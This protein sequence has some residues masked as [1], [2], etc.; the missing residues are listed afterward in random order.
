MTHPTTHAGTHTEATIEADPTVPAIHIYRDFA[1]T[2][3]QLF[4]A[5]TDPDLFARWIGPGT[6]L[7]DNGDRAVSD[8]RARKHVTGGTSTEREST[9]AAERS[10]RA[11]VPQARNETFT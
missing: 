10:S 2:R 11:G 9:A 7:S 1:A 8:R 6:R 3:E 5:H 4:R